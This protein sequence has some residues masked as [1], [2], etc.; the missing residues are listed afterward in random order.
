[1]QQ[2]G[3]DK[4][5]AS[6]GI[7]VW[8]VLHHHV[9]LQ[10]AHAAIEQGRV[11][12]GGHAHAFDLARLLGI[13]QVYRRT[14]PLVRDGVRGALAPAHRRGACSRIGGLGVVGGGQGPLPQQGDSRPARGV[15]TRLTLETHH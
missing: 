12:S 14:L 1:M 2:C 13:C 10:V 11:G 6:T 15:Q 8:L 5:G 4:E 3:R 9:V 7:R